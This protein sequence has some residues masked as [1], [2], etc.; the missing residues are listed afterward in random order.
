MFQTHRWLF[1]AWLGRSSLQVF[2]FVGLGTFAACSNTGA[3]AYPEVRISS[4]K[5]DFVIDDHRPEKS[6]DLNSL[7]AL[8]RDESHTFPVV[9]PKD[10]LLTRLESRI[11]QLRGNGDIPVLVTI[12]VLQS[13]A[14]YFS[15]YIDEFVRYDVTLRFTVRGPNGAL[16][17]RG[18]GG[19]WR[20]I[21]RDEATEKARSD[22][23]MA[24]AVEAFD[25]YFAHEGHLNGIN[26]ELRSLKSAQ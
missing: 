26:L 6:V 22:A 23:Q 7:G 12:E 15:H 17:G 9:L 2:A 5:L 13:D 16:L 10:A 4:A 8:E 11:A 1:S 20:K 24:A 18:K 21:P 14:T 25:R 19:A 3:P